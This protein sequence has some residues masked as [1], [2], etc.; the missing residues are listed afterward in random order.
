MNLDET[1]QRFR[2]LIRDRDTKFTAACGAVFTAINVRIVR[3]PVRAPRPN[4]IAERLS[5]AFVANSSPHADHQPAPCGDAAWQVRAVLQRSPAAPHPWG[6]LLPYDRS[7]TGQQED[8]E[9]ELAK[10]Q[11]DAT[12]DPQPNVAELAVREYDPGAV[13]VLRVI[14]GLARLGFT[15]DEISELT[16]VGSHRGPRPGLRDAAAAKLAEVDAKIA[17]LQQVHA[18]PRCSSGDLDE[19]S[20]APA[21]P[22]PFTEITP[23]VADPVEFTDLGPA[24]RSTTG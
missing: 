7:L 6:R 21:C 17:D 22:I 13:T 23:H 2:F 19:C 8:A 14:R 12:R 5:A 11:R 16:A 20:C 10:L 24:T 3:T 15:L 18:S 4:A 1:G 9:P